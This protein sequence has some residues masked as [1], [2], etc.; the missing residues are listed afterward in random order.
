MSQRVKYEIGDAI[1]ECIFWGND[2]MQ[3]KENRT[4]RRTASFKCRCGNTFDASVFDVKTGH[5]QSCGCV[6]KERT[7]KANTTHGL[8][9]LKEYA[10]WNTMRNRCTNP[11]VECYVRYGE[12]GIGV[13][14]RW[15]NSFAAFYEDMGPRPGNQYSVERIDN[16]LGYYKE[17][18]KWDTPKNQS[19]NRR[20]NIIITFNGK[21]QTL[22]RWAEE[23]KMPYL[24]LKRR[25]RNPRWTLEEA[26][27]TPKI[28]PNRYLHK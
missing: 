23:L 2:R 28:R 15:M 27:T 9:H 17:N 26:F 19:N 5:T 12:R 8:R 21:T 10:V 13:C 7:K 16:N 24:L 4:P 6:Q 22:P 14:E 25:I 1:G 11:N 20:G 3:K 18:C